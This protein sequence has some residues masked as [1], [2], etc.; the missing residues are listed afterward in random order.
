MVS[1]KLV[2]T[3]TSPQTF[4]QLLMLP[5]VVYTDSNVTFLNDS[6]IAAISTG[7]VVFTDS[8]SLSEY[9][10]NP[11]VTG[12]IYDNDAVRGTMGAV[13]NTQ[14]ARTVIDDNRQVG[15]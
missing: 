13:A 15:G 11:V 10:A 4:G 8:T 9:Q 14:Q 5:G 12:L 7:G 2:S 3:A 1:F 6:L